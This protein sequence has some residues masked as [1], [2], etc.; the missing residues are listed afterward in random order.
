MSSVTLQST[1]SAYNTIV[2]QIYISYFGRPADSTGLANFAAQLESIGASGDIQQLVAMYATNPAVQSL[3]DSFGTSAES[4]ALYTGSTS[5]FVASIYKNL[6]NRAPDPEGQA[7]WV[8]AIDSGVLSKGNASL[9][10][11]AGGLANTTAQGL[12]D[13]QFVR[14]KVAVA[15]NFTTSLNTEARIS[16]YRGDA[17]AATARGML[18]MVTAATNPNAYQP[19][20]DATHDTLAAIANAGGPAAVSF[21]PN[22]VVQSYG[23][24]GSVSFSV[25]ATVNRPEDF[26]GA[27]TIYTY[28]V[29]NVGVITPAVSIIPNGATGYIATFHSSASLPSGKY[30]G[31][32][33]LKLCRD[34]NCTSQFPGSPVA[35]PYEIN[36]VAPSSVRLTATNF[37]PLNPTMQVGGTLPA[38]VSVSVGGNGLTWS[39][40]ANVP[41][42]TLIGGSGNGNGNFRIAFNGN[43]LAPNP[44][45]GIITVASTDGQKVELPVSLLVRPTEF[46][47]HSNGAT[48]SVING[49][50]TTS[51]SILFTL[52]NGVATAWSASSNADWL[53]VSPT[54]GTTPGTTNLSVNPSA[55]QLASGT[56]TANVNFVSP[57]IPGKSLPVTLN[58]TKPTLAASTPTLTFGG[59]NGRDFSNQSLTLN[60]NT[61]TNSWPWSLSGLPSWATPSI[62][63]GTVSQTGTTISF[64]PNPQHAPTGTS[65]VVMN[66]TV[67]VNG[68]SVSVPVSVN[69]HK[70]QHRLLVSESGVAFST[71]PNWSRLTRT[72][73][74]SS[75]FGSVTPWTASSDKPWLSV[76]PTGTTG[77]SGTSLILNADPASLPSD[78]ISYATVTLTSSDPTITTPER[79]KVAFWK[80]SITPNAITK[81]PQSYTQVVADP[82]RP[83]AYL[84][85]AGSG[86]DVY[87]LYTATKVGN[88][89]SVGAA[90]GDMTV[91]QNGDYLYVLDTAAR[92][93]QV[94]DLATRTVSATW[95][96][97]AAVS[98][99]ST[100][101][102]IRPNGVEVVL[103][104]DGTAY[105]ATSGKRLSNSS[106]FGVITAS[107]DGKRVFTQDQG[108]SPAGVA[109][110]SVDYSDISGG[111]LLVS[112]LASAGFINGASNGKDIAVS[113]DGARL[114]T[115]SGA[116][117]RC[118][119]IQPS[120]LTAVGSLPGGD[121]YP[122][123][124]EVSNDGRVFCGI[125]GWYSDADVWV[126][127]AN[128]AL[129]NSYK[130][131]GYAKALRDRQMKLSGDGL[132]L[133]A[134]TD[135]PQLV[136]VPVGP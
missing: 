76:T 28:I 63:S 37:G 95:P 82:I 72:I 15:T 20:I 44:Y 74:V 121:A 104:G 62:N 113:N 85:S 33:V 40:T 129:L 96:L 87:N 136:F 64:A 117:Y 38:E 51:Q 98:Q 88:I 52:N 68:D 94:V 19:Y 50:P 99:S 31:N 100:V 80:G 9:S 93:I 60:L 22:K 115:A 57:N 135:D 67:K 5:A 47:I 69:I 126:H 45:S 11:M 106:I 83:L 30:Q 53:T 35:L 118:T 46:Q 34:S 39:A 77:A 120:D 16:G 111:V 10:I 7:F 110:Y 79:I 71:T 122:N 102:A 90:M 86:I 17:A 61:S 26:A 130:F 21:S 41:W 66:A 55:G 32:L 78:A 70:D 103:V 58:L 123:N 13:A 114:Y 3:I 81:L 127:G 54:A 12:V 109:S 8:K 49:A 1:A 107:S 65:T 14:N 84:H 24:G 75:N 42:A 29:D 101:K 27:S 125:S 56:Y 36:V 132:M 134:L 6:F 59:T 124:V 25:S 89:P 119:S 2:Q 105:L 43:G 92:S 48:F 116:P 73:K 97:A 112:Q 91:S 108:Y 18:A 4:N 23:A 133:V 131:A 128:G